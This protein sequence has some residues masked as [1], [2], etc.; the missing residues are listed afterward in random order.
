MGERGW[1]RGKRDGVTSE[2]ERERERGRD[3][4]RRD[5]VTRERGESGRQSAG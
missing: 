2:R 1:D 5:G 3:R 4:G